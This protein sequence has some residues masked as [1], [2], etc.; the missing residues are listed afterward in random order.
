ML[1]IANFHHSKGGGREAILLGSETQ[2]TRKRET[3]AAL[4]FFLAGTLIMGG[5]FFLGL[6]LFGQRERAIIY[7]SLF[8]IVYSYR[9]LG[10]GS[11]FLHNL[12]PQLDWH[13]TIRLEY[14]A[15]YASTALFAG[16]V[17]ELYPK[18]TSRVYIKILQGICAMLMLMTLLLPRCFSPGWWS[19]SWYCWCC[20]CSMPV[21]FSPLPPC[22]S[23][24]GRPMR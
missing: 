2:L 7:F 15:L 17:Y 3:E 13:L 18:E 10:F 22:A 6:Y 4:D 11:Y 20:I 5:L 14:L 24:T 8:S 12:L 19:C 23:A 1:Q 16:F 21:T 9:V